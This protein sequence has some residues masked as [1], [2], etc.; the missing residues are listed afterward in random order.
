MQ[1]DDLLIY[2]ADGL[3][4]HDRR[5]TLGAIERSR[6]EQRAAALRGEPVP[7]VD[8]GGKLYSRASRAGR[9]TLRQEAGQQRARRRSQGELDRAG[10]TY[11]PLTLTDDQLRSA[12]ERPWAG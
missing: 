4:E 2:L 8:D 11:R 1:G 12:A 9:T 3:S 6:Q 7:A 10:R 5:R